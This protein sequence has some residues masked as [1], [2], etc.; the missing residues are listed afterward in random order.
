MEFDFSKMHGAGNDFLMIDDR[1]ERWR[2]PKASIAALCSRHRGIGADG[3]ILLRPSAAAHFSMLY[4]NSDGGEADMCGNGARC[5]AAFAHERGIVGR[6]MDFETRAGIVQAEIL[7]NGVRIGIGEVRGISLGVRI[8]AFPRTVHYGVCGVPHAVI[9][10]DDLRKKPH[11]EFVRFARKVRHDPAFGT[12]G[13]NVNAVSVTGK[14]RCAYRT[15]ERGVEDETLACG[16]G[17][18]VVAT[19]LA[20]L[21]SAESPIL[22]ETHGGDALEV[23]FTKTTWGAA[24]CRLEGPVVVAFRGTFRLEDYEHP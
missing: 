8:E 1:D 7:E 4:Y 6:S 23:D 17:A 24:G 14:S 11:D 10:D 2:F 13:A 15:Y 3:L 12:A 16:T 18:V 21:E 5:A 19:V 20:H 22:C 9:I